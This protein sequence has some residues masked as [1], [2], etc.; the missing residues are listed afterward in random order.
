M[1]R[2]LKHGHIFNA[3]AS[4]DSFF[5]VWQTLHTLGINYLGV[6]I[7]VSAHKSAKLELLKI[8]PDDK[9]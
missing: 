5:G 1:L 7:N 9:M 4:F 3:L 8:V 6:M 2:M